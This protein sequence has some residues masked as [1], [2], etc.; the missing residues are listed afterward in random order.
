MLFRS[1]SGLPLTAPLFYNEA[2]A[3]VLSEQHKVKNCG[4]PPYEHKSLF[5][6]FSLFSP[7][8]F[9]PQGREDALDEVRAMAPP[10]HTVTAPTSTLCK[11]VGW[12]GDGLAESPDGLTR[13]RLTHQADWLAFQLHGLPGVTVRKRKEKKSKG[14]EKKK[15]RKDLAANMTSANSKTKKG[16][17]QRAQGRLRPGPGLWRLA[18]VAD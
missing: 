8:L 6:M 1:E 17:Q 13:I 10:D 7:L 16:R 4:G 2:R 11:L 14:K 5:R 15:Q 9:F 18:R 12:H 3:R